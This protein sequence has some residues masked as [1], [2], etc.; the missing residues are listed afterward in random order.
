MT[1]ER[2]DVAF[3]RL[4]SYSSAMP[5][6]SRLSLSSYSSSSGYTP[7]GAGYRAS[8][9]ERGGYAPLSSKLSSRLSAT[10]AGSSGYSRRPPLPTSDHRRRHEPTP[11]RASPARSTTRRDGSTEPDALT[12]ARRYLQERRDR[13]TRSESREPSGSLRSLLASEG[14]GRLL[15]RLDSTGSLGSSSGG[16]EARRWRSG[17]SQPRERLVPITLERDRP[18]PTR[19]VGE[20]RRQ[21]DASRIADSASDELPP[22]SAAAAAA[23][24]ATKEASDRVV[25]GRTTDLP[26]ASLTNG[27]SSRQR[28]APASEKV[29]V[30]VTANY[31]VVRAAAGSGLGSVSVVDFWPTKEGPNLDVT[32]LLVSVLTYF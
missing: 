26:A 30:R 21:F 2:G 7:R 12:E 14:A 32:K 9:L 5:V 15:E 17:E 13:L 27:M 20:L 18:E 4:A 10:S 29:R 16:G 22:S 8:S 24:A 23:A 25:G 6:S 3:S 19:T 11:A 31:A 1:S 28:T